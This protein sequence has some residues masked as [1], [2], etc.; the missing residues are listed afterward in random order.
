MSDA[1]RSFNRGLP[2][3]GRLPLGGVYTQTR[4]LYLPALAGHRGACIRPPWAVWQ[5]QAKRPSLGM[6]PHFQFSNSEGAGSRPPAQ[7]G[8]PSASI[9][10]YYFALSGHA[11]RRAGIL[12]P[13]PLAWA[14]VVR[15][16]G[17]RFGVSSISTPVSSKKCGTRSDSDEG[18]EAPALGCADEFVCFYSSAC[19]TFSSIGSICLASAVS[20]WRVAIR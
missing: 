12:G 8:R 11:A 13:R 14:E 19:L 17:A 18:K 3:D 6:S 16:F 2:G 10:E 1:R 20:P 5:S 4:R 15:P 7:P 9:P